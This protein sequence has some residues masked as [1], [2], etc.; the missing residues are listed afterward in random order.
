MRL[1]MLQKF[2]L[3]QCLA[4]R[5]STVSKKALETFY[6]SKKIRKKS[7]LTDIAKSIERLIAKDMIIG[8]GRKTSHKWIFQ[9]I[10]LTSLG[11]RVARGLL[12]KQQKLPFQG[13]LKRK[14][15]KT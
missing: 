5:R 14:N 13:S 2:I 7:I 8:I 6:S 15:I 4:G 10:E 3:K 12:G 9:E 11:R 1:S